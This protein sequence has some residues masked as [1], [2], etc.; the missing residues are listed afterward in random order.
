VA[1][2]REELRS[3]NLKLTEDQV[4]ELFRR[5]ASSEWMHF[6][7]AASEG[8]YSNA[9]SRLGSGSMAQG[10]LELDTTYGPLS[11]DELRAVLSEHWPRTDAPG[12]AVPELLALFR[13][14]GYVSDTE[15]RLE[16]ELTVYRG[17]FGDEPQ[18]GISWSLSEEK[19]TWF[20]RRLGLKGAA[21]W[22]GKVDASQ[23]LGY[24]VERNEYEV[25]VDPASLRD[26]TQVS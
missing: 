15:R 21:T 7:A 16:G 23:I 1:E 2:I 8:D 18:L 13:R 3:G 19:A 26:L 6:E 14:A 12:D 11:V 24:F 17:T 4:E 10:L 5:G 9:L 20:A 22:R 25:V